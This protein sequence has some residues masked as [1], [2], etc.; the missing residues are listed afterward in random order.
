MI[1]FGCLL[2]LGAG[3][4]RAQSTAAASDSDDQSAAPPPNKG[5]I[6]T[7]DPGDLRDFAA[8]PA[9][10]QRLLTEALRLTKLNLSYRYGSDDPASGGMDCSGTIHYLLHYA[11]ISDPPRDSSEIYRWMWTQSRFESVVSSSPE[12]FELSRLKPG[13]LLFWSGTYQVA[14]DP[15]VTHVMIYLGIDRHNGERVMMGASEGRRFEGISRYGVSVFD[16][17]LPRAVDGESGSGDHPRFIGYGA[18]PGLKDVSP[19]ADGN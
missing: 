8:Q 9:A 3:S 11:G 1:A 16:F 5:R 2:L 15:P 18:I 14:R 7:L 6:A 13:D 10:V 17:V 19:P 4:I 12:T